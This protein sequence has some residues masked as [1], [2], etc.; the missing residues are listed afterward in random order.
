MTQQLK[1]EPKNPRPTLVRRRGVV[2]SS[3]SPVRVQRRKLSEQKLPFSDAAESSVDKMTNVF[4]SQLRREAVRLATRE[5][6]DTVSRFH[7]ERAHRSMSSA[8]DQAAL[9]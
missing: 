5:S 8:P 6:L 9:P 3:S 7:I 2:P 4:F 1:I